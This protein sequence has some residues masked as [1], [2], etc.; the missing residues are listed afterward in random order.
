MPSPW[1]GK[2]VHLRQGAN[3]RPRG[4]ALIPP[5]GV[6]LLRA[7]LREPTRRDASRSSCSVLLMRPGYPSPS[8]RGRIPG[9][10]IDSHVPNFVRERLEFVQPLF[11]CRGRAARLTRPGARL[12]NAE[13][14]ALSARKLLWVALHALGLNPDADEEVRHPRRCFSRLVARRKFSSG[15]PSMVPAERRGLSEK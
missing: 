1:A 7:N 10:K 11:P 4:A 3:R 2:E 5:Q 9:I 8:S 6:S 12:G 13:P 14:L 15:S